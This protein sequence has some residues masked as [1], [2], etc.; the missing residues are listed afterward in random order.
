MDTAFVPVAPITATAV[1]SSPS[2]PNAEPRKAA[3][4]KPLR[5]LA[6][7][8]PKP[9]A[10]EALKANSL[11]TSST[12]GSDAHI[13]AKALMLAMWWKSSCTDKNHVDIDVVPPPPTIEPSA[14]YRSLYFGRDTTAEERL[15]DF[16]LPDKSGLDLLAEVRE[17]WLQKD[18]SKGPFFHIMGVLGMVNP[19]RN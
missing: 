1:A 16:L 14:L 4:K 8:A 13:L 19:L 15:S 9:S 2:S 10:A 3:S 17:T 11:K 5:N 6:A 12:H 7:A 18:A